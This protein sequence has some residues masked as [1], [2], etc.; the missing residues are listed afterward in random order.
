LYQ[1]AGN[2]FTAANDP[3]NALHAKIGF[4]RATAETNSFGQIST[5]LT[6]ELQTP[7][8]QSHPHLRLWCLVAK[9][10]TDIEVNVAAAKTDWEEAKALA[11]SLGERGWS[12]RASGE[13]GLVAFLQGDSKRAARLVG[14]ALLTSMATG[15]AGGQVRY[16]EL[17]GN[18]FNEL[19]RQE[20]ALLF[21]N[22]AIKVSSDMP[23]MGFP[24]MAYEG[25]AQ[26]LTSLKRDS[27][28]AAILQRALAESKAEHKQGHETQ[29]LILLGHLSLQSGDAARG[30]DDLQEA[31]RLGSQLG[32]YR[33][34]AQAMFD[35]AGQ[36]RRRGDLPD[37]V[38]R[39]QVGLAAS[40]RIGDRYYLP[41]NLRAL[42]ELKARTGD[43]REAHDL[44][45]Q[46]EDVIDGILIHVPG[47]YTE[48][49]LLGAMSD[50]YLED[51]RLEAQQDDV[52]EAF[53][54]IER[55][56]GRTAADMLRTTQG[57]CRSP[58]PRGRSATGLQ[59][60][61]HA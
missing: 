28:A 2:L 27:E 19:N 15:D 21:F 25:K 43:I 16:L 5:Y 9:G 36:Y 46:A 49:S 20:E 22:R 8:V 34:V 55:A 59:R 29:I 38:Q 48:S 4:I 13:L 50:I 60:Y 24:F 57:D 7:F 61:R 31:G 52:P 14:G 11:D 17:F 3:A 1:R 23:D 39:L 40:Q 56:R 32:F 37:A 6:Q 30:I 45:Q 26:A 51:F 10:M 47:A 35:L 53:A 18:A 12:N 42:A 33:M 58:M 54:I 41:R 44:Y